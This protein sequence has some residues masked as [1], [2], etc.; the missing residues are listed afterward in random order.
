MQKESIK[1]DFKLKGKVIGEGFE[2]EDIHCEVYLS[3]ELG[4]VGKAHFKPQKRTDFPDNW[5]LPFSFQGN[6]MMAGGEGIA[7]TIYIKNLLGNRRGQVDWGDIKEPYL[8][9]DIHD[10]LIETPIKSPHITGLEGHF[11]LSP[12]NDLEP[13]LCLTPV[14]TGEVLLEKPPKCF[15]IALRDKMSITFDTLFKCSDGKNQ[16][17]IQTPYLVAKFELPNESDSYHPSYYEIDKFLLLASL[18]TGHQTQCLGWVTYSAHSMKEHLRSQYVPTIHPERAR[19]FTKPEESL[20]VVYESYMSS[21]YPE[22]LI[23]AVAGAI[24]RSNIIANDYLKLYSTLETLVQIHKKEQ[25]IENIITNY[26]SLRKKLE[27]VIKLEI[28]DSS[29]SKVLYENLAGVNRTPFLRAFA[30]F[31]KHHGINSDDLWAISNLTNLRHKITHGH[32]FEDSEWQHIAQAHQQLIY[33]VERCLF[34]YLGIEQKKANRLT[35]PIIDTEI[36]NSEDSFKALKNVFDS[37]H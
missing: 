16:E 24:N 35:S 10:I 20:A 4:K 5:F 27:A 17:I 30:D 2:I 3:N 7:K 37:T 32:T 12:N 8:T 15:T 11:L 31:Q 22:R 19:E 25:G 33:L 29:K 13:N 34:I 18:V 6:Q 23:D 36:K 1:P 14:D 26:K 9:A 28:S 21:K